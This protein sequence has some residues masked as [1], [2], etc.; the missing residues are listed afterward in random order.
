MSSNSSVSNQEVR[1]FG[2]LLTKIQKALT[3]AE[4]SNPHKKA[5]EVM[6]KL[7]ENQQK[8]KGTKIA[9]QFK[10]RRVEFLH[11]DT[12]I[13][14]DYIQEK[15]KEDEFDSRIM[16]K[17]KETKRFHDAVKHAK[18]A[19][20]EIFFISV[21]LNEYRNANWE[22]FFAQ[23]DEWVEQLDDLKLLDD[24]IRTW[25]WG[26][27]KYYRLTFTSSNMTSPSR[28]EFAFGHLIHGLTYVVKKEDFKK[29]KEELYRKISKK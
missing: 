27:Q 3:D 17:D 25:K 1:D 20:E 26:K 14:V 28:T 6:K 21:H 10:T 8:Y 18:K 11:H 23:V 13:C 29:H 4:F 9:L 2:N 19:K 24:N 12:Q 15:T 22:E 5:M 16:L 7:N